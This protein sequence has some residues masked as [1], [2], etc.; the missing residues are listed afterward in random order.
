MPKKTEYLIIGSNNFWYAM[1]DTYKHALERAKEIRADHNNCGFADMESGHE[2][3]E[4][5]TLY[6][7]QAI[8]KK[9]I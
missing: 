7:Y 1:E 3:E 6:I 4:P 5:E 8:E 9:Q 2:P